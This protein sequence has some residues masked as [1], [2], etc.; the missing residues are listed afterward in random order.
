MLL[1]ALGAAGEVPFAVFVGEA[2][3][4]LVWA[5]KLAHVQHILHLSGHLHFLEFL[6]AKRASRVPSKPVVQA[7]SADEGLTLTARSVV[8]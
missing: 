5:L 6:L 1:C 4:T 8:F 2:L 7:A 3:A